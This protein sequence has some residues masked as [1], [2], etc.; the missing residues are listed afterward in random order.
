MVTPDVS[1]LLLSPGAAAEK[2]SVGRS[3]V[4]DLMKSGELA[5]FKMGR[6]R[7]I[8]LASIQEYIEKRLAS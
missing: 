1:P 6:S 2:L 7:R 4:Y 3:A 8:P 5:S